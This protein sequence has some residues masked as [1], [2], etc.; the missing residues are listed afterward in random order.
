MHPGATAATTATT[1]VATVCFAVVGHLGRSSASSPFGRWVV[2]VVGKTRRRRE[3]IIVIT[4]K[5]A[6]IV[7][8]IIL[9]V[10][11]FLSLFLFV[12]P[13]SFLLR[14]AAAAAATF[15][16]L[17][18]PNA[19]HR[20]PRHA[21]WASAAGAGYAGLWC[22]LLRLLVLARR[23]QWRGRWCWRF[24]AFQ[25]CLRGCGRHVDNRPV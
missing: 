12:R 1:F 5:V 8:I 13:R 14:L 21:H 4:V 10:A 24:W 15:A 11:I 20:V 7:F 22:L 23:R 19:N 6:V 16:T 9:V 3:T 18:L 2:E 25:Q 17:G